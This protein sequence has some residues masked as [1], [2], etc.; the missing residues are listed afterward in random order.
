VLIK[1]IAPINDES[2]AKC[3][4]KITKSNE[5]DERAHKGAYK[6]HPVEQP[7]PNVESVKRNKEKGMNQK[8][9]LFNR[10]KTTS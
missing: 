7:T 8:L 9:R 3:N 6:V 1:L 2:P 4:D 5:E 10:P